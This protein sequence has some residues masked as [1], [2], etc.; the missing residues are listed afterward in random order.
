MNAATSG[1]DWRLMKMIRAMNTND[2]E[3][4]AEIHV[5]GWRNAFFGILSDGFLFNHLRVLNRIKAFNEEVIS[6]KDE[7]YV[8]DDG[9]VKAFMTV[10][11]CRD[12]DEPDA[13]EL[14]GL[15]VDPFWQR[16]GIGSSMVRFCEQQATQRGYKKINL[17]VL[18]PNTRARSFYEKMGFMPDSSAKRIEW[19][20]S[21]ELRYSKLLK[22][23]VV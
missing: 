19:M 4:V 16:S 6:S 22:T 20:G 3:R 7:T 10:G 17:W 12:K 11:R 18:E 14:W 23:I 2:V 13:F 1:A 8:F 21:N 15:Y 9:I 5:T